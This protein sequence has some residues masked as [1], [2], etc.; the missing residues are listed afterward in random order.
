MVAT[1]GVGMESRN[2][3]E[4]GNSMNCEEHVAAERRGSRERERAGYDYPGAGWRQLRRPG[5]GWMEDSWER[6]RLSHAE[7][8]GGF[9][10]GVKHE[11]MSYLCRVNST[12]EILPIRIGD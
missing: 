3:R 10:G 8:L 12:E 7:N 9:P 1:T 11:K 2:D 4:E 5:T 6:R